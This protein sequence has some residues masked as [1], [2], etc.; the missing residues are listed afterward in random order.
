[1]ISPT[2][3]NII[4]SIYVLKQN[5]TPCEIKISAP[6]SYNSTH[7]PV[8]LSYKESTE[9]YFFLC[10]QIVGLLLR[11][12]IC[13]VFYIKIWILFFLWWPGILSSLRAS[14]LILKIRIRTNYLK[15]NSSK[16]FIWFLCFISIKI[17]SI[18]KINNSGKNFEY[19]FLI[20]NPIWISV[21]EFRLINNLS[22]FDLTQITWSQTRAWHS[23][24][25]FNF[26]KCTRKV[27]PEIVYLTFLQSI[28]VNKNLIF[29]FFIIS[30]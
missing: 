28:A 17:S 15:S 26:K 29:S 7:N 6:P 16:L 4:C 18:L 21:I 14:R 9:R 1:M 2:N 24:L 3:W 20:P 22:T 8:Y 13:G 23:R 27:E 5:F 10:F 25:Q 11:I 19:S 12:G 30:F